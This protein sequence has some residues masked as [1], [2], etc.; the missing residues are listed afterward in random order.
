MDGV[1]YL[2]MRLDKED[3][4]MSNN[5]KNIKIKNFKIFDTFNMESFKRVNLIGGKNNLG[6]TALLEAIRLNVSSVDLNN[7]LMSIR[8]I[9]HKR[10]NH[11]EID[12]FKQDTNKTNITT[13]K[14]D[15]SLEYENRTPE[16]IVNLAIDQI[17]QG[18]NVSQIFSGPILI[19]QYKTSKVNFISTG[20]ID[21]TY[22]SDLYASLVSKGKDEFLDE[23]LKQFDENIISVKQIVQG[24]AVFKLKMKNITSPILLNSLGDGINRFMAIICAIWASEDGYLFIDEVENGIHFTNLKK[25]WELIFS[26]SQEANCQVFATTHSQECI[27]AFNTFNEND[28]GAYFELYKNKKGQI[29][30]KYRDHEQLKYS[31]T[32]GGSFRG[33]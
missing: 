28:D 29:V 5:I 13:D 21:D 24:R 10:S 19:N 18:V 7:L 25:L 14:R 15:I 6:K 26:I 16:A 1:D 3:F 27:E 32:H 2:I 4:K 8:D 9:L 33:E 30:S 23:A 22:L 20:D 31:L 12:F 17:K 11:I